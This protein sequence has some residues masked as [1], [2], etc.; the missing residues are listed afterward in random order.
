M[1]IKKGYTLIVL[2]F[3][4]FLLSLSLLVA[5]PI[6]QTQIQR[7]KEEELIFRGKQYVEAIRIFQMKHPGKFPESLDRLVKE[8]CLR[9][10]YKDPMTER[11]EW[12]IIFPHQGISTKK[13][14]SPQ[15]ILVAPFGVLSSIDNPQIIGVVSSSSQGSIKIFH[16]QKT[17][18]KWLFFYGQDPEKMPEIIY[19]GKKE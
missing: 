13:G 19:Y 12:N 5:V 17:Y 2:V 15:K 1:I 18:D 8:K 9:R 4:V 14:R 7:E 3:A 10:F 16:N 11:G 6:F